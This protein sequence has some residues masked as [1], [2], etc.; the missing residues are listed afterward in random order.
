MSGGL[1]RDRIRAFW[2]N[3]REDRD[4]SESKTAAET[5]VDLLDY[6]EQVVR[7]DE[8][9]AYRLADYRLPDGSTVAIRASA[10]SGLPGIATDVPD[11]EAPIWLS[12]DRLARLAPPDP[13]AELAPWLVAPVDPMAS[14]VILRERMH[15]VTGLERGALIAADQAAE[16]DFAPRSV[17]TAPGEDET[18]GQ[19]RFDL[20]L[21]LEDRPELEAK[22][23]DWLATNW[24]DWAKTEATRRKTIAVYGQVYHLHQQLERGGQESAVEVAWGIGTVR[25][26]RDGRRI[27][28]PLIECGVEIELG[29]DGRLMVRATGAEPRVDLTPYEA[30]GC[31]NLAA[32]EQLARREILRTEAEDGMSPFRPESFE[33]LLAAAATRLAAEGVYQRE[34]GPA[35]DANGP[36]ITGEWVFFA[37]PRSQHVLLDDIARFRSAAASGAAI[38]GLAERLVTPPAEAV[39]TAWEPLADRLG[40]IGGGQDVPEGDPGFGD[41]FF[42]KPFNDD[43]V[44]IVARLSNVD[45]LVVQGPPGTGKTH[46]IANLICH[47][48]A[49]GQ[50]VLVVSRGEA[51]LSVLRDQL[52]EKV[53]PLTIAILSSERAG[54]RQIETAIREIQSVVEESRPEIR[55]SA[56][57]R[58]ESEILKIR[59]RLTAIDREI[60]AIAAPQS[61]PLGPGGEWPAELARRVGSERAAQAWFEDAPELFSTD[62]GLADPDLEAVRTARA[63]IGSLLDHTDANLPERRSLPSIEDVARWHDDLLDAR[64]SALEAERGPAAGLRV[65][66]EQVEAASRLARSLRDLAAATEALTRQAWLLPH[67]AALLNRDPSPAAARLQHICDV[68]SAEEAERAR[69]F[70]LGIDLPAELGGDDEAMA[71]VARA[72]RGERLWPLLSLGHGVAKEI[73]AAVRVGGLVPDPEGWRAVEAQLALDRRKQASAAAWRDYVQ[74]SGVAAAD[75]AGTPAPLSRLLAQVDFVRD[76]LAELA[77][78]SRGVPAL[79]ALA[80]NGGLARALSDQIDAASASARAASLKGALAATAIRFEGRDRTST[81]ARQFLCDLVGRD[82]IPVGKV[83]AIW[84]GLLDRVLAVEALADSFAELRRGTAAIAAAGA[85]L[86]AAKLSSE[87]ETGGST[88]VPQDWRDAWDLAAA[89]RRLAAIDGREA[90]QALSR[91]RDA[92]DRRGRKLFVE[93]VRERAFLALERRLSPRVKSALVEYVRALGRLGKGT[94]KGAGRHR[95]AA[96]D[97]MARCYDAVPCWIMPTW[98]VA[99]QLPADLAAFDLVI[100]DEASQSDVT[101]LPALLRGRK[102]LAVG[103]DRQVSP[104][105]PF[106]S[107]GKIDQLRQHYLRDLPYRSLLEPGESLYD[108]MR[109]VFP[110]SRLMLKEHFRCVEPIIRFSMQFY[111]EKLV[112]LR[113]PTAAERIDP[114][115]VDIFVPHGTRDGARKINP[116]EAHVIVE[117]IAGLVA[118]PTGQGRSIGVISLIGTEQAEL[119]RVM[120]M[121]RIGEEAMQRHA[122]LCSNSAGFQG[123]ERD[124]V[125][126]SMVADRSRRNTLTMLRYEQRFNV[127]ASRARDRLV[128]VRSVERQD[129]ASADLKARLIAHFENPMPARTEPVEDLAALC[130]SDFERDILGRLVALGYRVVPQVGSE[131]FRID[132]VVEDFEGRRL[133]VECDGDG[134]HG[135]ERWRDDMRRQRIL[136]RV[137][138]RFWRCF[139]SS[140]YRD[141]DSVMADLVATL[142]REGIATVQG[143]SGSAAI[144]RL[145]EHRV[146]PA[147]PLLGDVLPAV[148]PAIGR[149]GIGDRVA[150]LYPDRRRLTLRLTDG[151]DDPA[152][153]LLSV[154]TPLGEAVARSEEGDEIEV[155]D[156]GGQP[157]RILVEAVEKAA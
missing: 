52:P 106:V 135:P 2:C 67:V 18:E 53:R 64:R 120:L 9:I 5:L 111:P 77:S 23:Q 30:M 82:D 22:L 105:P 65:A 34:E 6:I 130:D 142:D 68:Q 153:G 19:I 144:A 121:E 108:L 136:E 71:A 26:E 100:L 125:F 112:P 58:C 57:R 55:L 145:V 156:A 157:T 84:D 119:V 50:R 28:R 85:P 49:L 102:I 97:A 43:Q 149:I 150:L 131:G 146:A 138:W 36:V 128:L 113:I 8:R 89:E 95:R 152:G 14:P 126:L 31:H 114:P 122:I 92:T 94:G 155:P 16:E 46:T 62:C 3:A 40:E 70:P 4:L 141:P 79:E 139:A 133:A 13:P 132:L 51:A 103:D 69:L 127:A 48:L 24:I 42:P 29:T 61:M 117:E 27:E 75:D 60:D 101:E 1:P 99:E 7:L 81:M 44:A 35:S 140:F 96:R 15:G 21:R 147:P 74:A 137:G 109:A 10:V 80:V 115:L 86:W 143:T 118:G 47:T 11:A 63:A 123:N 107:Q 104:T 73:V 76:R 90:L 83:E 45:G 154:A 72:A 20:R 87:P 17:D 54:M 116:A 129:L 37:R 124:I 39:S 32:L 66:P 91:E 151:A 41:V 88:F 78:R 12:I 148:A 93:L 25:W 98:R 38:A 33:P 59:Q 56:I 110:D 134:F